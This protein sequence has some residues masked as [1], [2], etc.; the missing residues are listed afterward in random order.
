MIHATIDKSPT[1]EIFHLALGEYPT[2]TIN[3]E[4]YKPY[5]VFMHPSETF[6]MDYMNADHNL[7]TLRHRDKQNEAVTENLLK[8]V[9]DFYPMH[10]IDFRRLQ[11]PINITLQTTQ[12]EDAK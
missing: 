7:I 3:N 2:I 9:D 11:E 1:T 10:F 12:E 8:Y 4:P 5:A 6:N